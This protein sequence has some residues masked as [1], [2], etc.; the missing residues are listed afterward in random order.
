MC[1]SHVCVCSLESR[2]TSFMYVL[3]FCLSRES[4][5]SWIMTESSRVSHGKTNGL[6]PN[7]CCK[8]SS[9]VLRILLLLWSA[10]ASESRV[11]TFW[12]A[13][14]CFS[15][16]KVIF[17]E[18]TKM[19]FNLAVLKSQSHLADQ[20]LQTQTHHHPPSWWVPNWPFLPRL[21]LQNKFRE[22]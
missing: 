15:R 5:Q 9:R 8:R 22:S 11:D 6:G 17:L 10:F 19:H 3:C 1:F 12:I 14:S 18:C 20:K 13:D 2:N 4:N 7:H 21:Q 16:K